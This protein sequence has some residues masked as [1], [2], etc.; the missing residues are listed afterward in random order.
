MRPEFTLRIGTQDP[1]TFK[2]VLF[3]NCYKL[4]DHLEPGAR[5]IDVGANIG[6]FSV[7]CLIRGAGLVTAVEPHPDNFELLRRNT[8]KWVGQMQYARAALW[9]R[10]TEWCP[11]QDR[12]PHSAMHCVGGGEQGIAIT[13]QRV[14]LDDL[15]PSGSHNGPATCRLLKLDCEGG[16]YPGLLE[17]TRLAVCQEIIVECH[18]VTL[19]EAQP[20]RY[21]HRHARSRLEAAGFEITRVHADPVA[22]GTNVILWARNKKA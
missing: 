11:I 18:A 8:A 1:A 12:G 10:G 6:A 21:D 13:A 3:D 22:N 5:I 7:A 20:K 4:P 17:S 19:H 16:E 14:M 2:E 15:I 9:W